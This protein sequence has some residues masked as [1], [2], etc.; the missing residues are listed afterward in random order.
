MGKPATGTAGV[1]LSNHRNVCVG[2]DLAEALHVALTMELEL[3]VK[4]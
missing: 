2:S 4:S 3:W 1:L